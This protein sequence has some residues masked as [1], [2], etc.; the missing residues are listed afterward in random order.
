MLLIPEKIIFIHIPKTGGTSVEDFIM[1]IYGYKRNECLLNKGFG[2]DLDLKEQNQ[3]PYPIMHYRLKT[4]LKIV[5]L[6]KE[7]E[8]AIVQT[9]E[10][11][12]DVPT[13]QPTIEDVKPVKLQGTTLIHTDKVKLLKNGKIIAM[14]VDRKFAEKKCAENPNLSIL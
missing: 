8:P 12:Q 14:A 4:I 1:D 7:I 6:N 5:E 10:L 3:I 2:I 13:L 11:T 9:L